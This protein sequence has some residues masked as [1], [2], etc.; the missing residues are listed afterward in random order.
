MRPKYKHEIHMFLMYHLHIA[1]RSFH[2]VFLVHLCFD[3]HLLHEAMEFP[4]PLLSSLPTG[5]L[6][7]ELRT[8][9]ALYHLSRVSLSPL[10]H[11]F[12][13]IEYCAFWPRACL[14]QL[15]FCFCLPCIWDYIMHHTLVIY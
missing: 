9:Y 7:F 11:H 12:L 6:S 3:C 8:R 14:R 15:S 5:R 1:Q 10:P 13:K 4:T 2:T